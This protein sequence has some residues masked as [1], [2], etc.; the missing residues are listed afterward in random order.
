MFAFIEPP[1][2]YWLRAVALALAAAR[3]VYRLRTVTLAL[4]AAR[5][6]ID[7]TIDR[8]EAFVHIRRQAF[9]GGFSALISL[10]H[11]I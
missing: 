3:L 1:V 10:S 7:Y 4:A 9:D 6:S 11:C 5:Q 2:D 8:R